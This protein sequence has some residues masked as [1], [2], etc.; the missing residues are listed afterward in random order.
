[1][2]RICK[3]GGGTG[4]VLVTWSAAAMAGDVPPNFPVKAPVAY[5][6]KAAQMPA[7]NGYDW[8]GWYVGAH[9]G[10]IR[11][12]SNWSA[13]PLGAGGPALNG[14]FNL[15][16]NFDFMAGTGSYFLGLQGGYNY[17]FPSRV[18]LGV[19]ALR[20]ELPRRTGGDHVPSVPRML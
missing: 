11:G 4:V 19:E 5:V 15:P 7:A 12:A 20:S 17:I 8:S 10:V 14:S 16:F 6:T 13:I 18:M 1:M 2:K 9:I 3:F